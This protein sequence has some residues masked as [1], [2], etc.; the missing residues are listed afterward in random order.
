MI[1][2][3]LAKLGA[4]EKIGLLL[5]VAVIVLLVL[6]RLL[7]SPTLR[8]YRELDQR[9]LAEERR[10]RLNRESIAIEDEVYRRYRRVADLVQTFESPA[11]G[12][13]SMKGQIDELA[14]R[15]GVIL[16]SREHRPPT[17]SDYCQEYYVDIREFEAPETNLVAFLRL[18]PE[19]PGLLRVD[20][21]NLV[22]DRNRNVVKGS[23][24]IS[25]VLML[26]PS[27]VNEN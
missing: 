9:I 13:D 7:I 6:D 21:I 2:D 14:G 10:I 19:L 27:G 11:A 20:R 17:E 16:V 26:T 22:P 12:I 23:M 24:L 3:R 15:T 4:R 8:Y 18:V 1:L 25:K 5:A